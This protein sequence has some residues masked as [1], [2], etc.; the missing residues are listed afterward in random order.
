M[1]QLQLSF[2]KFF[3]YLF[4]NFFP[5]WP[6]QNKLIV[7]KKRNIEYKAEGMI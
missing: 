1:E 7:G 6:R 3:S 4:L 5:F 2:A